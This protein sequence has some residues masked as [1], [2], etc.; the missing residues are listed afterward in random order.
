MVPRFE[1]RLAF[2]DKHIH[3]IPENT[4]TTALCISS[5]CLQF[6]HLG[7]VHWQYAYTPYGLDS[8][9][10]HWMN[11]IIPKR[12]LIDNQKVSGEDL[13]EQHKSMHAT[14]Q[15]IRFKVKKSPNR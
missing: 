5:E 6:S 2:Y 12:L 8:V 4:S 3:R 13:I 10:K 11:L 1:R 14:E 15:T 9:T 7:I